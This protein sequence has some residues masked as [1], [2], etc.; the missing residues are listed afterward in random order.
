M[1]P[2]FSLFDLEQIIADRAA[3]ADGSSY[4]ASLLARGT[5]HC[6]RKLGEEAVETII[7]AIAGDRDA[8]TAEAADLLYH[9]M[10]L[11]RSGG[12]RLETVMAELGQRTHQSGLAEKAARTPSSP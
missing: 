7:S 3:A 9:L 8:L 10:V 11:L 4:T 5:P 6:A 2:S 12:V 1:T